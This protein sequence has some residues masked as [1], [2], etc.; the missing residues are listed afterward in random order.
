MP[1]AG[2][3]GSEWDHRGCLMR[4]GMKKERAT[5]VRKLDEYFGQRVTSS[6]AIRLKCVDCCGNQQAEV[7]RCPAHECP[8]WPYR[9]GGGYE[10][11]PG[12]DHERLHSIRI[13]GRESRDQNLD[14]P[15]ASR[16]L[17]SGTSSGFS[18]ERDGLEEAEC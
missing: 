6:S 13:S 18:D 16:V 1:V 5:V 4:D 10:R 7:R 8:L 2:L 11:P 15:L 17:E 3:G 12:A 14:I 9:M